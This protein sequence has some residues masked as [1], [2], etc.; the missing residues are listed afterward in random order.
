MRTGDYPE[1]ERAFG[2]L[3][4]SNDPRTRDEARLARAQVL[5]AEGRSGEARTELTDLARSGA[6][7]LVQARAAEALRA[8]RERQLTAPGSGN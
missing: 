7:P 1:A 3:A 8:T 4:R 5:V 6:T 2:E